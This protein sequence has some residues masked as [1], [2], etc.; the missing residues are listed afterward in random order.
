M[1]QAPVRQMRIGA[2]RF[3]RSIIY[4]G[5]LGE[6]METTGSIGTSASTGTPAAPRDLAVAV[7]GLDLPSA[8]ETITAAFEPG[9]L[10]VVSNF[11]PS[12]LVVLHTLHRI[13][14]RLP[15]IFI[16]TL[17]H[18]RETL[19]HVERVREKY[20]LDLRIYRPAPTRAE[21]ERIHGP[22]LWKRDLDRYQA[23]AKVAPFQA[24]TADLAAWI[25]GRRRD[26]S[27]SRDD[28]PI[29]E[30]GEQIRINPL[31]TWNRTD[32]WRTI[33]E[34]EI[35]YNPLH[36]RGYPSVGDEPLTTPVGA[37]E[38]ERAGRWRGDARTECGIHL[39]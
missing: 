5:R 10:A 39:I 9:R 11:G 35:P 17:H 4:E 3:Q 24:A 13:G 23:V 33:L 19:E 14:I 20:D 32:V 22:E 6:R 28:L 29:V 27:R 38:D 25:T 18:F 1:D 15:V 8:L 16:D 21:F 36:D 7:E 31:A 37:G 12:T 30:N 26:Q 34:N 2:S